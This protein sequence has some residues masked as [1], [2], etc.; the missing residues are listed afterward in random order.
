MEHVSTLCAAGTVGIAATGFALGRPSPT[1]Q[2]P[3]TARRRQSLIARSYHSPSNS[4]FESRPAIVAH[5]V[6]SSPSQQQPFSQNQTGHLSLDECVHPQSNNLTH[7]PSDRTGLRPRRRT[8]VGP[9]INITEG[10]GTDEVLPSPT[11]TGRPSSSWIRRLS[12]IT[13]SLN[14]SSV[15]GSRPQSPSVN[16]STTPFF[17]SQFPVPSPNKLVKRSMSSH[18]L[19]PHSPHN[20]A[21]AS[22]HLLRRPATSHQRSAHMRHRSS[23]DSRV[24]L[25]PPQTLPDCPVQG[26]NSTPN[27]HHNGSWRPYFSKSRHTNLLDS[28]SKRRATASKHRTR[29]PHRHIVQSNVP[30][31]LLLASAITPERKP[32]PTPNLDQR[33]IHKSHYSWDPVGPGASPSANQSTSEIEPLKTFP[34]MQE[35]SHEEFAS[36]WTM[37]RNMAPRSSFTQTNVYLE[38]SPVDMSERSK[39]EKLNGSS[40]RMRRRGNITDPDI[41]RRPSTSS[42]AEL[43]A[44]RFNRVG[45]TTEE[46]IPKARLRHLPHFTNLRCEA[47]NLAA[48]APNSPGFDSKPSSKGSSTPSSPTSTGHPAENRSN[49]RHSSAASDPAST[50][51]GSDNDIKVFSS[52]EEDDTDFQSDIAF[53]SFP[54]RAASSSKSSRRGPRIETIFDQPS[55]TSTMT[56]KFVSL[57]NENCSSKAD[58]TTNHSTGVS[59]TLK[60]YSGSNSALQYAE[61]HSLSA[62]T[63]LLDKPCDYD[64]GLFLH[65]QRLRRTTKL[66]NND[67]SQSDDSPLDHQHT[68]YP[69]PLSANLRVTSNISRISTHR[70]HSSITLNEN[71]EKSSR[72]CLYD[73]SEQQKVKKDDQGSGTRP[74]TSH[75][76]QFLDLRGGRTAIR[77]TSSS[78][79]LRSQSVPLS[80]HPVTPTE[81]NGAKKFATWGLGNKGASEDWDGDFDFGDND[82]LCQTN[83]LQ[84]RQD[85]LQES[86]TVKVPKA[87]MERQESVYGQFSHVQELTVLVEELKLLRARARAMHITEGPSSQLWKE[88]HGI[89]SLATFEEGE[90]YEHELRI[91]RSTS[92]LTFSLEDFEAEL[93][94]TKPMGLFDSVAV[95]DDQIDFPGTEYPSRN[96]RQSHRPRTDSSTKAKYV[97][98]TIHRERKLRDNGYART[99]AD[100]NQKLAFDT[101]SLRD[102]VIR[103]GVVTRALKDVVRKAEGV[104]ELSEI[105]TPVPDPPFSKIFNQPQGDLSTL[106]IHA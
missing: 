102:L 34:S 97:L 106:S 33:K 44:S 39:T 18:G 74:R 90:D 103:A 7:Q 75:I 40:M 37:P 70:P 12:T 64:T 38:I 95:A 83:P 15:S 101:Q 82:R 52:G 51:V 91:K 42:H 73:W 8:Y 19:Q 48:A 47:L 32:N 93:E 87:I 86:R 84:E 98:D 16:S 94:S 35:T 13:S 88:A 31:T 81:P 24:G 80:Q 85:N 72:L 55:S 92:S 3:L 22:L 60:T 50:L 67:T 17:P 69:E 23:T 5:G 71:S 57:A 77:R 26:E 45:A 10:K 61:K 59:Q 63:G 30:P 1:K 79:H 29:S 78:L 65:S 11:T 46:F 68:V 89:I 62:Q 100:G 54:T 41:F 25:I 21:P 20:P 4:V 2:R 58:T 49:Q 56:T 104:C 105:D 6:S 99:G 76:E 27:L 28:H 43:S 36:P 9:G 66:P 53:D 96:E 14:G